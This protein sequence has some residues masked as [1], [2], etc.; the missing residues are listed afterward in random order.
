MVIGIIGVII[1]LLTGIIC[2]GLTQETP[3]AILSRNKAATIQQ[4]K[5]Y[6]DELH[7][8]EELYA[9]EEDFFIELENEK[10]VCKEHDTV[11]EL[12]REQER[13][14]Q[15]IFDELHCEFISLRTQDQGKILKVYLGNVNVSRRDVYTHSIYYYVTR[16]KDFGLGEAFMKDWYYTAEYYPY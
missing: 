9:T 1:L 2:Y 8:L 12:D 13:V 5:G 6:R 4:I 11:K 14:I 10:I 15:R 7:F 3:R 16:D